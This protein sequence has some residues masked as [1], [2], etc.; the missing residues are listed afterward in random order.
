MINND[1]CRCECKVLIDN[2]RY[3]KGSVWNPSNCKCKCDKLCDFGKYLDCKN[4]KCRKILA[5][6]LVEE[7]SKNSDKM[8]YNDTLNDYEKICNSYTVYIVLLVIFFII[9]VSISSVFIYF[10]WYLKR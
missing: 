3:D 4:C 6:K 1:K 8:I 2:G 5:D 7:C 9:S 10:Y